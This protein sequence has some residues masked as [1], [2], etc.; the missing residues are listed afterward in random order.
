VALTSGLRGS[1]RP[2]FSNPRPSWWRGGAFRD[3]L[4][5]IPRGVDGG[6]TGQRSADDGKA[7]TRAPGRTPTAETV[8][9]GHWTAGRS[10]GAHPRPGTRTNDA[11][12]RPESAHPGTG[13]DARN[14]ETGS[15]GAARARTAGRRTEED[16]RAGAHQGDGLAAPWWEWV[17]LK[18]ALAAGLKQKLTEGSCEPGFAFVEAPACALGELAPAGGRSH[19]GKHSGGPPWAHVG[20]QGAKPS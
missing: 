4:S 2:R 3:P 9:W 12:G 8:P 16:G 15:D 1:G 13:T 10:P 6:E 5:P 7:H 11:R 20:S 18:D 19:H 17:Q 14:G